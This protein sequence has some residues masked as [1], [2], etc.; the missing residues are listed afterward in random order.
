VLRPA[1]MREARKAAPAAPP[2]PVEERQAAAAADKAVAA[3]R[4]APPAPAPAAATQAAPAAAAAPATN[5]VVPAEAPRGLVQDTRRQQEAELG[6]LSASAPRAEASLPA[7][8]LAPAGSPA[9]RGSAAGVEPPGVQRLRHA[10]EAASG[11]SWESRAPQATADAP[12]AP[13][14]RQAWLQQLLQASAGR[15]VRQPGT[16]Q[17]PGESLAWIGT[18]R[19]DGELRAIVSLQGRRLWWREPDGSTWTATLDPGAA[20]ALALPP[21]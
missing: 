20:Q 4:P 18:W 17:P 9:A 8:R 6:R 5:T 3:A 16:A 14:T 15:W 11:W 21:S 1:P 13:L 7:T 2:R 19:E 12:N 10:A